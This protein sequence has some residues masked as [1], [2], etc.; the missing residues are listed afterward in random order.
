VALAL[1]CRGYVQLIGERSPHG[2]FAIRACE[3]NNSSE[4]NLRSE[5]DLQSMPDI[6]ERIARKY[7]P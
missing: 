1:L 6:D 4:T 2:S 3:S 7:A 5:M